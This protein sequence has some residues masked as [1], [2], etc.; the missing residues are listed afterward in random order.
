MMIA[1]VFKKK[2]KILHVLVMSMIS[3]SDMI[4]ARIIKQQAK[5]E[6]EKDSNSNICV[7]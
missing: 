6:N 1:W 5:V 4:D 2:K 7:E 3:L